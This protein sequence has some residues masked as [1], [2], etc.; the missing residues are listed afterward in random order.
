VKKMLKRTTAV[1]LL[2]NVGVIENGHSNLLKCSSSPLTSNVI[3]EEDETKV[4]PP[5]RNPP[6][7][8]RLVYASS[9]TLY[10]STSIKQ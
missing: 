1:P 5:P 10:K 7:L 6:Q 2:D 3:I 8:G 4:S 9:H